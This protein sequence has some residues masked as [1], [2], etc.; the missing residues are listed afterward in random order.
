MD[1]LYRLSVFG[2]LAPNT[3]KMARLWFNSL[4]TVVGE[5]V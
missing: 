1:K 2:R 4:Y 5:Q 3:D